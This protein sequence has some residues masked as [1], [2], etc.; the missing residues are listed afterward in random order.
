MEELG[1]SYALALTESG[2]IFAHI[3]GQP[4]TAADIQL[5]LLI[6]AAAARPDFGNH[7]S[8][9]ANLARLEARPA[10]AADVARGGPVEMQA[11]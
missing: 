4:L 9:G 1:S 11:A 6:R 3:L 8:L 10:F 7:P 5:W 2:G